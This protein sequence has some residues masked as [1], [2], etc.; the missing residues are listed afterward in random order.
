LP[1]PDV[2]EG[3][4]SEQ[5]SFSFTMPASGTVDLSITVAPGSNSALDHIRCFLESEL[6]GSG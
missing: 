5:Y 6:T 3:L 2:T 1:M 4:S